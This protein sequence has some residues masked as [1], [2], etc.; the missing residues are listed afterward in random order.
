MR[1]TKVS[2]TLESRVADELR[3]TAGPRGMSA[4]VNEAVRQK[5][6]AARVRQ[7]LDAME[8]EDGPIR[9]ELRREAREYEWP[10]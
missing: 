5:L 2:V 8:R 7:L 9:E 4:F 1:Y 6:Q 3:R 10:A